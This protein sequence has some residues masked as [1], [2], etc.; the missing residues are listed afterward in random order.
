MVVYGVGKQVILRLTQSSRAGARTELGNITNYDVQQNVLFYI[1][2][3]LKDNIPI[4][5]SCVGTEIILIAIW[6]T[7][8]DMRQFAFSL[9]DQISLNIFM[10]SV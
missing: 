6:K 4:E 9:I 8:L 2:T 5:N 7:L 1:E 3:F 10:I